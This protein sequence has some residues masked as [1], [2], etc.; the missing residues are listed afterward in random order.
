MKI[1]MSSPKKCSLTDTI[2]KHLESKGIELEMFGA[3]AGRESDY[4]R[5][6]EELARAVSDGRF[7]L[8]VLFCHTGTGATLIANKFHGVRA[9]LCVDAFSANVARAANNANVLVLGI[10]VTGE[11][12]AAEII[13]AWLESDPTSAR[14]AWLEFHK[15]TGEIDDELRRV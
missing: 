8:G 4:I 5:A 9:A 2:K 13:D 3:L 6:A 1:A 10:R 15:R 14:P 7:E 12:L 11:C